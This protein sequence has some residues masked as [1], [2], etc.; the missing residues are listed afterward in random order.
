MTNA[1]VSNFQ[2]KMREEIREE[3][4]RIV[5]ADAVVNIDALCNAVV[6]RHM[7]AVYSMPDA[8]EAAVFVGALHTSVRP[9]SVRFMNQVGRELDDAFE[10]EKVG[11][12]RFV[13]GGFESAIL[14]DRYAFERANERVHAPLAC[15]TREEIIAKA[16]EYYAMARGNMVHGDELMRYA[17]WKFDSEPASLTVA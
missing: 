2:T 4:E 13:G 10:E 6:H 5:H 7:P 12:T 14:Q 8:D 17:H 3:Y 15:M 16:N 11:Q 1:E 9:M